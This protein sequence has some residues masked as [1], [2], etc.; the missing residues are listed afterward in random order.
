[1]YLVVGLGNPESEG[2]G[3]TRHNM[4]FNTINNLAKELEVELSQTKFNSLYTTTTFKGKK[5]MLVKPQTYMNASGEAVVRF[6]N[7]Y[8]FPNE[9]IIVIY[10]DIDIEKGEIRIRKKGSARKPQRNEISYKFLKYRRF[11]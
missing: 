8:K 11:H 4:G 7:F 2:Y 9:N 6:K 3:K 1:M 5:I 10:D